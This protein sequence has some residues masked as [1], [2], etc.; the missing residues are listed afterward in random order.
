MRI[1][2]NQ[3]VRD[4]GTI[5]SFEK[6]LADRGGWREETLQR[7]EIQA[8]FLYPFSFAPLGEWGHISGEHLGL[9]LGGCLSPTP[10]RQPLFETS[11]T[12]PF[13]RK[14]CSRSDKASLGATL[15]IP[16]HSRSNSRN[17]T[18]NLA[19]AKTKFWEQFSVQLPEL[20]GCQSFSAQILGGFFSTLGWAPRQKIGIATT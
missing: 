10:S 18:H 17:C 2:R 6:G 5:R 3:G 11:E 20:V 7:P 13:Q 19:H 9:F 16:G 1:P 4:L 12:T 15:G 14:I 8:S